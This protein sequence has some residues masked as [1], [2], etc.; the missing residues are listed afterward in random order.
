MPT[1]KLRRNSSLRLPEKHRKKGLNASNFSNSL[2]PRGGG[3]GV[4]PSQNAEA[5]APN[6]TMHGCLGFLIGGGGLRLVEPIK[7]ARRFIL[8]GSMLELALWHPEESPVRHEQ[9]AHRVEL[10]RLR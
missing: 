3:L 1:S 2:Y 7:L 5:P 8:L 6:S 4:T 10:A 9:P